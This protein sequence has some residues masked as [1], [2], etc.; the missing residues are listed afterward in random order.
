MGGTH[1]AD[2]GRDMKPC[3][4]GEAMP[5]SDGLGPTVVSFRVAEEEKSRKLTA[6]VQGSTLRP[7]TPQRSTVVP[8]TGLPGC[9]YF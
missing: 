4:I 7:H 6:G 8:N 1:N 9:A 2:K 3:L 5:H